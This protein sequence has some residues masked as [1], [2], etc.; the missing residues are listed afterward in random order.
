MGSYW[1][2]ILLAVLALAFAAAMLVRSWRSQDE[3]A[4]LRV[5][6]I[7]AI[8]ATVYVV[9]QELVFVTG[10]DSWFAGRPSP[11]LA[12]TVRERTVRIER[13]DD[14]G[15]EALARIGDAVEGRSLVGLGE[16]HHGVEEF[17]RV[18]LALIRYLHEERDF[19]LLLFESPFFD[20]LPIDEAQSIERRGGSLVRALYSVWWTGTNQELFR[21]I[22]STWRT[23]SPLH[24][25]AIDPKHPGSCAER[26]A[27]FV[28][29]ILLRH[30]PA[31]AAEHRRAAAA[32]AVL[33]RG[34]RPEGRGSNELVAATIA[35]Y[36]RIAATL[37]S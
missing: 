11:A 37:D 8:T 32:G 3:G 24:V 17:S 16:N 20:L 12:A 14:I 6:L 31:L 36:R 30:D 1:G 19:D 13:V 27:A 7:V 34:D 26:A 21:Y 33:F 23:A 9:L 15:P 25:A 2:R 18:K 4:I 35:H 29:G 10:Y 5:I 22:A 28:G